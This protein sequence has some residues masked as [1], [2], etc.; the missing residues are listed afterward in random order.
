MR[1]YD[2]GTRA[3]VFSLGRDIP[4]AS[5]AGP[6]TTILCPAAG[7][8][9]TTGSNVAETPTSA[10]TTLNYATRT[11]YYSYILQVVL[12]GN[13]S[14]LVGDYL[15][16]AVK[17]QSSP[18][19]TYWTDFT[20]YTSTDVEPNAYK[21]LYLNHTGATGATA[22]QSYEVPV[23]TSTSDAVPSVAG[24][25]A[26]PYTWTAA[27]STSASPVIDARIFGTLRKKNVTGKYIAPYITVANY[28]TSVTAYANVNL[29][30]G[31]GDQ[32]PVIEGGT[33]GTSTYFSKGQ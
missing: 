14:M 1:Y 25:V 4:C 28:G 29:I 31:A 8:N 20:S 3:Q 23:C 27:G 18:D 12:T 33:A 2:I 7:Y 32:M 10:A 11:G 15:T 17:M 13:A 19:L 6:T 5:T 22:S 30:L 26:Q 24:F 9:N 16:L 21:T